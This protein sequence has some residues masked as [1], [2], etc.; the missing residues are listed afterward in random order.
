MDINDHNASQTYVQDDAEV[1]PAKW[2]TLVARRAELG[3]EE[4]VAYVG[5]FLKEHAVAIGSPAVSARRTELY[6]Q[7]PSC[8]DHD[9]LEA[10]VTQLV[11]VAEMSRLK[12]QQLE[13]DFVAQLPS[14]FSGR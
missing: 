7:L 14:M 3:Q 2:Q 10:N 5:V 9:Q 12:L 4:W 1:Q 11:E 8:L 13:A 6:R